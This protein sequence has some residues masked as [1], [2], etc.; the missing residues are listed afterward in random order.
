MEW[1]DF[2][3]DVMDVPNL[4][5]PKPSNCTNRRMLFIASDLPTLKNVVEEANSKW[6]DKYEIYS[7]RFNTKF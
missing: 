4:L 6:S 1:V 7:G 2:W 5:T 3:F